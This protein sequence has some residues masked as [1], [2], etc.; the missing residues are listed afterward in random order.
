MNA[1]ERNTSEYELQVRTY[2]DLVA[3]SAASKDA[4]LA[5]LE[6]RVAEPEAELAE[7]NLFSPES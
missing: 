3:A 6:N 4:R 5:Y 7:L 1:Y 2:H